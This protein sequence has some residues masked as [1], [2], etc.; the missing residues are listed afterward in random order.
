[1]CC[2]NLTL[3]LDND[4]VRTARRRAEAM[5]ASV[6]R[7]IRDYLARF[8]GA[9]DPQADAAEYLR[10]SRVS[11]GNSRGLKFNREELHERR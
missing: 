3:S 9:S 5:G 6:H 2:T 1:M 10:L 7:L 4:V 8:A 11:T